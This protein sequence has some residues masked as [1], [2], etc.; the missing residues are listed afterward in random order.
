MFNTINYIFGLVEATPQDCLCKDAQLLQQLP[1]VL[2][3]GTP[4]AYRLVWP[5]TARNCVLLHVHISPVLPCTG[6]GGIIPVGPQK[7]AL[8]L[9]VT[10]T[11]HA[12]PAYTSIRI[13]SNA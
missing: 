4:A 5:A 10:D 11:S 1:V 7:A 12:F 2:V 6:G 8:A 9:L 13:K 3:R